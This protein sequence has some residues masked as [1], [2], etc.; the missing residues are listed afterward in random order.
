[1]RSV[2]ELLRLSAG[3]LA[4]RGV[5]QPRRQAE[6]LLAA[7]LR[8]RRLDLYLQFDRPVEPAIVDQLRAHLVRR[9]KAEPTQYIVGSVHFFGCEIGVAPGVLVPRPETELLVDQIARAIEGQG[10]LLDLCCGS[11]CIAIALKRRF[12]GLEVVGVDLSEAAL[13]QA[14]ENGGRNG[15]EV[16]WL[17]S[18]LF[19]SVTG[20]FDQIVS[21]PPYVARGE[22][23]GLQR[24]VRDWEPEMA[25]V[26]GERGDE[27]Y[28]RIALE[29]PQFLEA[30]GRLWLEIGS[31]QGRRVRELFNNPPWGECQVTPD[32]SGRDRFVSVQL[33]SP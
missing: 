27:L 18:D 5:E 26:G 23:A 10:R 4:E 2:E 33:L 3:Y 22:L 29:A 16:E 31:E 14:R 12:P 13:E 21:N 28:E 25:L 15:V 1:M 19:E 20:K 30:G 17:Q 32:W 9:G 24:E 8:V 6:E 11:G 7:L